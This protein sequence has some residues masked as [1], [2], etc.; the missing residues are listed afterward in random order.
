MLE[1]GVDPGH[2]QR[3]DAFGYT[4]HQFHF[5]VDGLVDRVGRKCGTDVDNRRI[6]ACCI[7]RFHQRIEYGDAIQ[8]LAAFPRRDPGHDLRT[9]VHHLARMK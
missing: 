6:G 4:D 5:G 2:V 8:V 7:A 3:G 1:D 9:V